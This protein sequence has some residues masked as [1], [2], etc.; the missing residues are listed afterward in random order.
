MRALRGAVGFG[1]SRP[2][3]MAPTDSPWFCFADVT[4]AGR[5][6]PPGLGEGDASLGC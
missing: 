5:R 1:K 2:F 6:T 3:N 4:A